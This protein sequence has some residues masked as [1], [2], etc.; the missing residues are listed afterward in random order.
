[1]SETT[2]LISSEVEALFSAWEDDLVI[3]AAVLYHLTSPASKELMVHYLRCGEPMLP[4]ACVEG[5]LE[6]AWSHPGLGWR[7]QVP[8]GGREA[9][10]LP[11]RWYGSL[12]GLAVVWPTADREIPD[13]WSEQ[14][15]RLARSLTGLVLDREPPE[16]GQLLTE[17]PPD[18]TEQDP[19]DSPDLHWERSSTRLPSDGVAISDDL[20]DL[21]LDDFFPIF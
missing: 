7:A 3:E 1:M 11:L 18:D 5:L 15:S 6:E 16:L 8:D 10:V 4:S 12:I 21:L 17:V 2:R 19:V 14:V 13:H 20:P 9:A